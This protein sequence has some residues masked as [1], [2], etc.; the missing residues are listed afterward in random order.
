LAVSAFA[1][2]RRSDTSVRRPAAA[3]TIRFAVTAAEG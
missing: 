1:T 2:T 3:L